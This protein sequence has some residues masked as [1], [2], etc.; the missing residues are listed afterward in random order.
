MATGLTKK[1]MRRTEAKPPKKAE[2]PRIDWGRTRLERWWKANVV[3]ADWASARFDLFSEVDDYPNCCAFGIISDLRFPSERYRTEDMKKAAACLNIIDRMHNAPYVLAA[4]SENQ[5]VVESFLVS[6][7][8][9]ELESVRNPRSG[10][11]VTL[12]L[13]S[14]RP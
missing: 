1:P 4:T 10:N 6:I 13:A 12:W 11:Q 5:E 8:F 14:T 7:G 9:R 3:N 2:S